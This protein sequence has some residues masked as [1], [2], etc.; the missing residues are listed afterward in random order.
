MGGNNNT[1]VFRDLCPYGISVQ[2]QGTYQPI[3]YFTFDIILFVNINLISC[4]IGVVGKREEY[5]VG[6][7]AESKACL[8]TGKK[9]EYV[10]F[11]LGSSFQAEKRENTPGGTE[12]RESRTIEA[13]VMIG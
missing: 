9:A 7:F 10:N 13:G 11:L 2:I 3:L 8:K 12:L 4:F 1:S 5:T 6:V